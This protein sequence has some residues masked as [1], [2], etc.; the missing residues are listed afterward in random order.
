VP[1]LE[2]LA[3]PWALRVAVTLRIPELIADGVSDVQELAQ[4]AQCDAPSL[5]RVLRHL[6]HHGVFE[7]PTPGVFGLNDAAQ[8]LCEPAAHIGLDLD[9][10]GGRMSFVWSTLLTAVRTGRPAYHEVFRRGFWDDLDANPRVAESF[11]AL[12]GPAGHGTPD[13]EIL[14]DGDWSRVRTVVDVGGGTGALIDAVVKAHAGV[15]GTLVDLPRTIARAQ[16]DSE[17]VTL[18]AQSFFDPLPAGGDVYVLKNVLADWPDAEAE[19]LLRRCAEAARP[20]GR[21]M[22]LGGVSTTAS[23]GPELLM[24]VLVGGKSR[25]LDEFRALANR[26]GLEVT[27]SGDLPSGRFAVECRP[28]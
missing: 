7:E 1:E 8:A 6:V 9:G 3:T 20:D 14:L 15:R 18:V 5:E 17:R 25:T 24:L 19:A 21:V 26:A 11:E 16:V 13:P 12:M 27:R 23:A 22:V 28:A 4:R 2:D 10:I